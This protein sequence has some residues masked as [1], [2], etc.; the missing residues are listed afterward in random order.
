MARGVSSVEGA[1]RAEH[2][3]AA[4]ALEET[5]AAADAARKE[6]RQAKMAGVAAA[7]AVEREGLA[8]EHAAALGEMEASS[9]S[10]LVASLSAV[11]AEAACD[12]SYAEARVA[13]AFAMVH[14]CGLCLRASSG[15]GGVRAEEDVPSIR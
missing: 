1:L 2:A 10:W 12:I 8:A 11:D 6:K 14:V 15:E 7:H 13:V 5:R 3:A 4:A 9:A